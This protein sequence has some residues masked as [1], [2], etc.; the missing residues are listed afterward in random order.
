MK[1][2][3]DMARLEYKVREVNRSSMQSLLEQY[4]AELLFDGEVFTAYYDKVH[5]DF[6][7]NGKR[8]TVTSTKDGHGIIS[9]RDK[10]KEKGENLPDEY[11]VEV[12]DPELMDKILSGVGFTHFMNFNKHR[13]EFYIE[14]FNLIVIFEKYLGDLDYIPEFMIIEAEEESDLN[15]WIEHAGI[16]EDQ[17]MQVSVMDLIKH[18]RAL[19]ESVMNHIK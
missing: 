2:Y 6:I 16:S 17:L 8:L 5:S 1:D 7:N 4:Q 14:E 15:S 12:S 11:E 9:F 13:T 10:Y 19:A 3:I 18:Y